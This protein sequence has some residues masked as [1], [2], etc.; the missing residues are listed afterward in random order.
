MLLLTVWEPRTSVGTPEVPLEAILPI[1]KRPI[2]GSP[3]EH[4]ITAVKCSDPHNVKSVKAHADC[5]GAK[6]IC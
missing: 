2:D 4:H 5:M 3:A 6:N 1:S